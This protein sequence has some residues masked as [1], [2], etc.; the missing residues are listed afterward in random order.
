MYSVVLM[1]AL[2]TGAS[3][4]GWFCHGCGRS[5][6]INCAGCNGGCQ[7][8]Y[9]GYGGYGGGGGSYWGCYG[10]WGG[11]GC[12]ASCSGSWGCMGYYTCNGCY[13]SCAGASDYAPT[14]VSPPIYRPV[15]VP[16]GAV[17]PAAPE[18]APKPKPK[19]KE[20]GDK[21]NGAARLI[22]DVPADAKLFIDDHLMKATSAERTFR[23]PALEPGQ[24][25]YYIV[26]AEV[27]QDGKSYREEKRV[28]VRAGATIRASFA[29]LVTARNEQPRSVA[30]VGR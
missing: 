28:V 17:K 23:T 20:N 10:C 19:D 26:R 6:Y 16:P 11:Y 7:G 14:Y 1:A 12:Y 5:A 27:A 24:A 3:E 15:P 2:S 8:C 21:K 30:S 4:P 18:V 13:S 25:Y 22:I 29:D 9:G